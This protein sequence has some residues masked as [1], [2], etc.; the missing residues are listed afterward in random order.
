[1]ESVSKWFKVYRENI[2]WK[3][4]GDSCS[5]LDEEGGFDEVV[6][7]KSRRV[8]IKQGCIC[9]DGQWGQGYRQ[10]KEEAKAKSTRGECVYNETMN[11]K[12]YHAGMHVY[13]WIGIVLCSPFPDPRAS[14]DPGEGNHEPRPILDRHEARNF[15]CHTDREGAFLCST[16]SPRGSKMGIPGGCSGPLASARLGPEKKQRRKIIIFGITEVSVTSCTDRTSHITLLDR[17]MRR[18][19]SSPRGG[20][21]MIQDP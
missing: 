1:M 20:F 21:M 12:G 8:Q 13:M 10:N 15:G 6:D 5:C 11:R 17:R 16:A 19:R 3:I 18:T 14:P 4:T 9:S 7:W 2:Y